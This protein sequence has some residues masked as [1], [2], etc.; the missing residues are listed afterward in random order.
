MNINII[1][2]FLIDQAIH[3]YIL[4]EEKKEGG[5]GEKKGEER[6]RKGKKEF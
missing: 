4:G 2:L 5:K 6:K 1:V 3:E